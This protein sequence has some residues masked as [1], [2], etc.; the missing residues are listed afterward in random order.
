MGEDE[1]IVV[2]V[3]N[4]RDKKDGLGLIIA[5]EI[6]STYQINDK[7]YSVLAKKKFIDS[8]DLTKIAKDFAEQYPGSVNWN[9][10][11]ENCNAPI[12]ALRYPLSFEAFLIG[13]VDKYFSNL[14]S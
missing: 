8:T 9:N 5:K 3:K 6:G 2:L 14:K 4:K 13:V 11:L 12:S 10:P 7:K 1:R